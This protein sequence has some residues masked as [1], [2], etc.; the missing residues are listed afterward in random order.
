MSNSHLPT[1]FAAALAPFA[2]PVSATLRP[3][4]VSIKRGQE[5]V[6]SFECMAFSSFDAWDQHIDLC[7][8]G[9]GIEVAPAKGV[10]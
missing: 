1:I 5:V 6:R 8:E 2:P 7:G 4:I 3:F 10:V 9:E